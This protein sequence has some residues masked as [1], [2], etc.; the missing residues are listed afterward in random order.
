MPLENLNHYLVLT[1]DLDGTRDFYV[2]VLGLREGDRPPLN[3]AGYWAYVGDRAVVHI[4]ER[5]GS[6]RP[7]GY[8]DKSLDDADT[9]AIDHVAFEATGLKD[10][11][12]RLDSHKIPVRHRKIP[13]LN[14]HQ[15]FLEDPNGVTIELNYPASEGAE[16]DLQPSE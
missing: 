5:K 6:Q 13:D 15:I 8:Y 2:D 7:E 14:L 4:A 11:I 12:A 1:D 16:I 10:M 9:G 3:F